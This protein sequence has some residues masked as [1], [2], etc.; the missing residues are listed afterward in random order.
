MRTP[1]EQDTLALIIAGV[2]VCVIAVGSL[3]YY[4]VTS[5]RALPTATPQTLPAKVELI[6]VA[7]RVE[8]YRVTYRSND[9]IVTSVGEI[10]GGK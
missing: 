3:V 9:F 6:G 4:G 5:Q 2:V 7:G 10:M 8:I 1:F